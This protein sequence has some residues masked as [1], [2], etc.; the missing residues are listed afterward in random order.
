MSFLQT[1]SPLGMLANKLAPK[2]A[3]G[4]ASGATE[5]K[6]KISGYDV[7]QLPTMSPTQ[8]QLFERILG[9]ARPGV[10]SSISDISGLARGDEQ[11]FAP[12]EKYARKQFQGTLGDIASRFSGLGLGGRH[13]SAFENAVEGAGSDLAERLA[14]HRMGYQRQAQQELL[15]LAQALLGA[16]THE[17]FLQPEKKSFWQ[18]LFGAGA[19]ILGA[20]AGAGLGA[21]GGPGGALAGAQLGGRLGSSIGQSLLG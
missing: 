7:A 11:A 13:G 10:E 19:P 18:Q 8:I 12:M 17:T 5:P 2:K 1:L 20:A 9:S 4:T 3:A 6:S 21:L 15:N 14:L 16:K